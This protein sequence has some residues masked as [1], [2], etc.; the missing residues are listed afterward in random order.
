M[1]MKFLGLLELIFAIVIG[2]HLL[3]GMF[4]K[5]TV[6]FMVGYILVRGI[7]FTI[8]SKDIASIIDLIVGGYV[9][10]AVNGT[11]SNPVVTIVSVVWLSQKGIFSILFGH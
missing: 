5:D 2:L 11:F 1:M 10:L 6:I 3:Y 9:L 7:I 8:S 4:A